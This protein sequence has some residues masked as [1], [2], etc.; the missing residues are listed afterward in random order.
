MT[1]DI[2]KGLVNCATFIPY[3]DVILFSIAQKLAQR[4]EV[5]N[6]VIQRAGIMMLTIALSLL[7]EGFESWKGDSSNKKIDSG[8]N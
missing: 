4:Y 3:I 6:I 1:W 2:K 8:T 7:F 5:H